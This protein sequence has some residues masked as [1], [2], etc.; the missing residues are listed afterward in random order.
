MIIEASF[1]KLLH[2]WSAQERIKLNRTIPLFDEHS[3]DFYEAQGASE[4]ANVITNELS[5]VGI[6]IPERLVIQGY[7]YPDN[8][9][10]HVDIY[11]NLE[12]YI[13]KAKIHKAYMSRNNYIEVKLFSGKDNTKGTQTITENAGYIIND[14]LRMALLTNKTPSRNEGISRYLLVL[15]DNHPE[16]YISYRGR[17]R[18][19]RTW[20][21]DL[22]LPL[23]FVRKLKKQ[24]KGELPE[25]TDMPRFNSSGTLRINL[26]DVK[27]VPNSMFN[28]LQNGLNN[29]ITRH[30][31]LNIP[32]IKYCM[33]PFI[34]TNQSYFFL[35]RFFEISVGKIK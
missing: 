25:L 8:S 1:F 3:R 34:G 29:K 26:S 2:I 9:H 35:F 32:Y 7:P 6:D 15:F 13:K 24:K 22:L 20:I 12:E 5:S 19:I 16:N 30:S 18:Q 10:K 33:F 28:A 27:S 11:V 31:Q 14:I 4:F 17:D 23:D 21:E